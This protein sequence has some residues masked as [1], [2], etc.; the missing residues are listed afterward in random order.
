MAN[1]SI[2][3]NK[4]GKYELKCINTIRVR[5]SMKHTQTK[6]CSTI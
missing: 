1:E 4:S 2:K 5:C 6:M 3:T